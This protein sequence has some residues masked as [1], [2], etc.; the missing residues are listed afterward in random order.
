M[1]Y[2]EV[3]GRY[4]NIALMLVMLLGTIVANP[5]S[6]RSLDAPSEQTATWIVLRNGSKGVE[7]KAVQYLLTSR[8]H[9]TAADGDFGSKTERSVRSFQRKFGLTVNGVDDIRIL[10]VSD[11]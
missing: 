10:G 6:A 3:K 2:A 9:R 5:V 11:S 4:W 7:V 1:S 8:G